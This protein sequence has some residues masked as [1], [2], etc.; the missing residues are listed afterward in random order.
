MAIDCTTFSTVCVQL[1]TLIFEDSYV[2]HCSLVSRTL[3]ENNV[4]Y[5]LVYWEAESGKQVFFLSQ[6][7]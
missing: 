5:S 6:V 7:A 4:S 2:F 1:V 3:G